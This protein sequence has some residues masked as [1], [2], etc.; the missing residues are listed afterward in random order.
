VGS[1]DTTNTTADEAK[2][3]AMSAAR[4]AAAA[5]L[6]EKHLDEYNT[7][8]TAEAKERGVDW[9]PRPTAEQRAAEEMER[10]LQQFPEL[11][12]RVNATAAKD[13]GPDE[14]PDFKPGD[15]ADPAGPPLDALDERP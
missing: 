15:D 9:K 2:D 1:T 13:D 14:G 5:K 6:R 10:L 4:S 11:A 3:K 7:L 8:L 12:E